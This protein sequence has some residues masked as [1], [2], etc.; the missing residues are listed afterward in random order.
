VGHRDAADAIML[1]IA[2]MLPEELRGEYA[3]LNAWRARVGG[4]R[5]PM[6]SR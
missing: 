3:D 6:A 2:E 4:L 1:S 5:Q